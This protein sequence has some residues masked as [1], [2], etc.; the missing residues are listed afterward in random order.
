MWTNWF[1]KYIYFLIYFYLFSFSKWGH[2][3]GAGR[4][5]QIYHTFGYI[6]VLKL[7]H[8]YIHTKLTVTVAAYPIWLMSVRIRA[9]TSRIL[10][11]WN[12]PVN[13]A[14][15]LNKHGGVVV[16]IWCCVW[17]SQNTDSHT[18]LWQN[19]L[20]IMYSNMTLFHQ[21][22]E[23]WKDTKMKQICSMHSQVI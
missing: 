1:L 19:K 17:V 2:R 16:I 13:R 22:R 18:H 11:A 7:Y 20:C 14:N 5:F 12:D 8:K 3:L 23:N 21:N 4:F 6:L 9:N 15:K 10:T